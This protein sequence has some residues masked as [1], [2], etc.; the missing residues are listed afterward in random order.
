MKVVNWMRNRRWGTRP[1]G[2]RVLSGLLA[3]VMTLGLVEFALPTHAT[4]EGSAELT[5]FTVVHHHPDGGDETYSGT[6]DPEGGVRLPDDENV[7]TAPYV[8]RPE[9]KTDDDGNELESFSGFTVEAGDA[10]VTVKADDPETASAEIRYEP[11]TAQVI[12]HVN[13]RLSDDGLGG[14]SAS[15]SPSG[16]P[17]QDDP[18]DTGDDITL[19]PESDGQENDDTTPTGDPMDGDDPDGSDMG[20]APIALDEDK[21]QILK[22]FFKDFEGEYTLPDG[23]G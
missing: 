7:Y 19:P 2:R 11:G 20:I 9:P 22:D 23:S 16:A 6:I 13:Y 5:A 18:A 1:A 15:G 14:D 8:V 17:G 4:A 3:L 10:A 21:T 12:L